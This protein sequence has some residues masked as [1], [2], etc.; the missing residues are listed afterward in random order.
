[1][2]KKFRKTLAHVEIWMRDGWVRAFNPDDWIIR[3]KKVATE[4]KWWKILGTILWCQ[5]PFVYALMLRHEVNNDYKDPENFTIL[6]S[7]SKTF[8]NNVTP[9]LRSLW[10]IRTAS[11]LFRTLF[12]RSF[13]ESSDA[14]RIQFLERNYERDEK[15]LAKLKQPTLKEISKKK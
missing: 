9:A 6:S 5:A 4:E 10:K 13:K 11:Q 15:F 14:N 3:R 1:M 2:F 12:S 8:Q 7:F